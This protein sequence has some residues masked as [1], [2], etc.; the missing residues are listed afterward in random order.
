MPLDNDK[1]KMCI[2]GGAMQVITCFKSFVVIS[3]CPLELVFF[4][5][6][7]ISVIS[8][9]SVGVKKK[10]LSNGLCRKSEKCL[11]LHLILD[12]RDG[13]TL[14]KYELKAFAMSLGLVM[15]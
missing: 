8:C 4:N 12:A 3:S 7:T 5:E 10:D 15:S 14:T 9:V 2:N 6:F 11:S 1:L 13:P